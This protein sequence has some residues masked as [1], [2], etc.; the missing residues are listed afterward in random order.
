VK[1]SLK[2]AHLKRYKEI[3]RIL[4]RYGKKDVIRAAPF[5]DAEDV[6]AVAPDATASAEELASDFEKMGPTF[7]KLG[8]LLSTRT[9]LF[10][11]VYV[12]ALSRLHDRVEP[13]DPAEIIA[14]IE[15]DL[16]ARVS[17][18]FPE[19]DPKPLASASLG[20]VHRAVLRDGREVAVKVQRPDARRAAMEDLEALGQIAEI[21]DRHTEIGRR[22]RFAE[23]LEEFRRTL[24]QE[25][26][27]RQEAAH[28][29][30]LSA[31]LREFD[32]II[33]PAAVTDLTSSRVLTMEHIHGV[34]VSLL[35]PLARH[36]IRSAEL[37]DQLFH[38]YLKQVLVDGFVHADPH[39]GNVFITEDGY[40]ALLDLGMVFRLTPRIQDRLIALLLAVGEGRGEEAAG[41][42]LD[43]AEPDPEADKDSFV[44]RTND[45]IGRYREASLKDLEMGRVLVEMSRSA[46]DCG[47]RLPPDIGMVG[48]TLLKLDSVGR[49][50]AP[51]FQTNDAIR[52]HALKVLRRRLLG[53]GSIGTMFRSAVEL[54][55]FASELPG[56]VNRI[57]DLVADNR[58]KVEV[59]ALDETRLMAGLQKIA[60]RITLGLVLA[61]LII[62]AALLVRV[63]SPFRIFGYPGMPFLLFAFA[64]VGI[65]MLVFTIVF[66]DVSG[67]A[68]RQERRARKS[69]RRAA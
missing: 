18:I 62:G 57:L 42:V 34:K 26:D 29:A 67:S 8:Q 49:H 25:L 66:R 60:N 48:Q 12:S 20:Q 44:R 24:L 41:A 37:A 9:D 59:D 1:L 39:P 3:V 15:E 46:V 38:A 11:E 10:P 19:F 56:R 5:E 40:L 6:A 30:T 14:I 7:I 54:K 17:R 55:E 63:E 22:Y 51:D 4:L 61:A 50:L 43:L 35:R 32:R 52:R 13:V 28:L 53:A 21:L 68:A 23:L 65:V 2:P 31:N 33:V 58:L 64:A 47:L 36:E 45:I 69:G 16:G 27:Y